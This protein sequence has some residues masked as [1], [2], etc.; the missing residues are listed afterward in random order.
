[1]AKPSRK[2][3]G[4]SRLARISVEGFKSIDERQT[5]ELAPLTVLAGAN[6][7]GKSSMLQPLLLLKQTLEAPF[8]PG[9]LLLSGQNVK[10]TTADQMLFHC[11]GE[12]CQREFAFELET[13]TGAWVR[14]VY[15][16]PPK[17]GVTLSEMQYREGV[18]DPVK[19]VY[20]GMPPEEIVSLLPPFFAQ[21]AEDAAKKKK[22]PLHWDVERER[23]FLGFTLKD[24][25]NTPVLAFSAGSVASPVTAFFQHI[26][27]VLHLPG[28]RGNPK[29]D[30]PTTA[31]EFDYPGTFDFY[32]ASVINHWQKTSDP[33]VKELGEDLR[34][35][36]LTWKVEARKIDD[37]MVELRVGRLP[38]PRKGGAKDMVNIADVGFGVSQTLPVLVALRA[39]EPGR[40]VYL[41]QP[42]I[43]LH[44]NAQAALARIVAGAAKRGVIVVLETHSAILLR[45]IQTLVAK[46]ELDPK[47]V[48]LN[49]FKRDDSNGAT[50]IHRA[51]P[52]ENGAYGDWPEDFDDVAIK[53]ESDYLD[54]IE[55]RLH[56]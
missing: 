26:V 23:F 51:I 4:P 43:H 22:A 2:P 15:S 3:V 30:Y 46:G 11:A 40:I 6:S 20:P 52:D 41:E 45:S 38:I 39:A 36:G 37:T 42:E 7:A 47:E 10:F 27:G 49:W 8:D 54:A 13:H 34:A 12:T 5:L 56:S 50:R 16:C 9:T 21:I 35:L 55:M 48:N 25:K 31:V 19:R 14:L 33:R 32:V 28:L 53:V 1:M 24:E 44:P 18:K 29:R 17:Q